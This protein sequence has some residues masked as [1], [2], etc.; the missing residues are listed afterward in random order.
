MKIKN[1]AKK[2]ISAC[3]CT[4]LVAS[5]WAS[6]VL[7][8]Y[9]KS[10]GVSY[11]VFT[12]SIK[13]DGSLSLSAGS[14]VAVNIVSGIEPISNSNLPVISR[15]YFAG[16]NGILNF[17]IS[18]PDSFK[19]GKYTVYIGAQ[20][21]DT[22]YAAKVLVFDKNSA[23]TAEALDLINA[24]TTA[25]AL[26]ASVKEYAV[27][28]GIDTDMVDN[29]DAVCKTVFS[30]KKSDGNFDYASFNRAFRVG[31]AVLMIK[32]GVSVDSVMKLYADIL[33]T[34]YMVYMSLDSNVKDAFDSL[35]MRMEL[36]KEFLSFENVSL[37]ASIIGSESYGELKDTVTDNIDSFTGID[38]D[39]DY[40]KLSANNRTKVFSKMFAD[41]VEYASFEDVESSF[42]N[43][44]RKLLR[45]ESDRK[46]TSSGGSG[47]GTSSKVYPVDVS[48]ITPSQSV[49]TPGTDVN[50]SND[51]KP[52]VDY[53]DTKGH[54]AEEEIKS[55]AQK[56]IISGFEDGTF[57]P[58]SPVTRAQFVKLVALAFDLKSGGVSKAFADVG[59]GEWFR[60]YVDILSSN[61]IVT[62]DGNNFRPNDTIT[63]Q[64]ATVILYNALGI[65][66]KTYEGTKSFA[67]SSDIASYARE[68]V[69]ALAA[70]G[71][72]KGDEQGF[73]PLSSLSRAEAAVLLYRLI[74]A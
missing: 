73:R 27:Y 20:Q 70:N 32:S 7:A 51:S 38:L 55:L 1:K 6:T 34:D 23:E 8:S 13:I 43:A 36:E 25:S 58:D 24:S 37:L 2:L 50:Q 72:I 31:Q 29:M 3:L 12:D 66:G 22:A 64:D 56:G 60:E 39:G 41:R 14:A 67:D 26:T 53:I 21:L 48:V 40:K 59:V 62:G 52:T 19:D 49:V 42:D 10:L 46:N 15:I 28:L 11:D 68:S 45:E 47:S 44:V 57:Q 65:I 33:E 30:L 5:G 61:N 16:E 18:L 63:R 74:G 54:F 69:E 17:D 9:S 4:C 71:I 35:L